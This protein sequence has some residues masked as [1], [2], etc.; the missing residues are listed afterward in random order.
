M[1]VVSA[2]LISQLVCMRVNPNEIIPDHNSV[3]CLSRGAIGRDITHINWSTMRTTSLMSQLVCMRV[4]SHPILRD[5]TTNL[6]PHMRRGA[7]AQL[8]I[9][10]HS[11]LGL[12]LPN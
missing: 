8:Y 7:N 5:A 1:G 6:V 12:L 2:H 9:G 10:A 3:P 11:F 4:V